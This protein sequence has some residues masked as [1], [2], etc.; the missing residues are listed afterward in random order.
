[1]FGKTILIAD[2]YIKTSERDFFN[3]LKKTTQESQEN[4]INFIEV[5]SS[6]E[7]T[8]MLLTKIDLAL[9]DILFPTE[10]E[11][12]AL[13]SKL[14]KKGIKT[15]AISNKATRGTAVEAFKNADEFFDKEKPLQELTDKI[16]SL[17]SPIKRN[18]YCTLSP[19]GL[20]SKE[21]YDRGSYSVFVA[22]S[23]DNEDSANLIRDALKTEYNVTPWTENF[24]DT[25]VL[26]CDKIC[27]K[28]YGNML[29]V[30]EI[31]DY[32]PNVF[33]EAGFGLGLGRIVILAKRKETKYLNSRFLPG[34]FYKEY[35][36]VTK[37]TVEIKRVL[38][39]EEI[40]KKSLAEIHLPSSIFN[41]LPKFNKDKSSNVAKLLLG[42]EDDAL[43]NAKLYFQ[44]NGIT[45][46]DIINI[47]SYK[48][49]VIDI[50]KTIMESKIVIGIV[51]DFEKGKPSINLMDACEISMLLGITVAQNIDIKVLSSN[52]V[53]DYQELI[54]SKEDLKNYL[55]T[56]AT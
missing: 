35:T 31:S 34:L 22:T 41:D 50:V 43:S 27:P 10:N 4:T 30:A 37:L 7:I 51:P 24:A 42:A 8:D 45:D 32:N 18:I 55:R 48:P 52:T 6:T 54:Y 49:R 40:K 2:D 20:C 53:A 33:F 29:L 25:G 5:E 1:M 16:S 13:L 26:F 17:L 12:M 44:N 47:H 56:T 14:K 15:I 39:N 23:S 19:G 3:D 11:G 46:I 28:I 9:V 21:F 36:H 38:K